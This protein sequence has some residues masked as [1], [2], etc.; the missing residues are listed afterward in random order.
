MLSEIGPPSLLFKQAMLVIIVVVNG[1]GIA[2]WVESVR[3]Q[4]S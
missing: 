1:L 4:G 3:C 2:V